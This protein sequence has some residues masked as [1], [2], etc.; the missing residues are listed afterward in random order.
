MSNAS[1]K[2]VSGKGAAAPLLQLEDFLPYRL[3]VAAS[4][5]SE[6]LARLYSE[7]FGID[8][9]GWRVIATLGQV[10][11]AT[12]KMIGQHSH[13][14]KTKV[15][16]AV[17]DLESRSL[18]RRDVNPSDKREAILVLTDNGRKVYEDIVP[19]AKHYEALLL[20]RYS[21]ADQKLFQ[22]MLRDLADLS[23]STPVP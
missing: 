19:L 7:R 17:S 11:Q 21:A 8:I 1:P 15:S 22:Q 14:H 12:A 4:I 18:I 2:P 9:P 5:V 6:G 16:R 13:M 10:G 20:Q 23:A 3:N